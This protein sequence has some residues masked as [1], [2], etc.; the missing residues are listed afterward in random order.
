MGE[1]VGR[2]TCEFAAGQKA[3]PEAVRLEALCIPLPLLV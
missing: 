2:Y 1:E 3:G